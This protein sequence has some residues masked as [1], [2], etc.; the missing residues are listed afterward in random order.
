MRSLK[1]A[2][3]M[4]LATMPAGL[5]AIGMLV[6]IGPMAT[7]GVFVVVAAMGLCMWGGMALVDS[8]LDQSH[9]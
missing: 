2:T 4:V 6:S 3:G 9:Q 5:A 8:A 7:I 1:F